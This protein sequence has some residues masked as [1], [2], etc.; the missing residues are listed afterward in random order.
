MLHPDNAIRPMPNYPNNYFR[1]TDLL[2]NRLKCNRKPFESYFQSYVVHISGICYSHALLLLS[3][4]V[5]KSHS[6][7][8]H[9]VTGGAI[10]T[11]LLMQK[12]L[13][14]AL[15][16]CDLFH[17][18]PNL[19]PAALRLTQRTLSKDQPQKQKKNEMRASIYIQEMLQCSKLWQIGIVTVPHFSLL[20]FTVPLHYP[21]GL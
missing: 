4:R 1:C 6:S 16:P 13:Q 17:I 15:A 7:L 18:T 19:Y 2:N 10:T 11:P 14:V 3:V 20:C 12:H 21:V 5:N 8:Q 9:C